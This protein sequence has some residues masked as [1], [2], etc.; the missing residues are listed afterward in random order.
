MCYY[1]LVNNGHQMMNLANHTTEGRSIFLLYYLADLTKAN[2]LEGTLLVNGLTDLTLNLLNLNC[3][4]SY[5]SLSV[6]YFIHTDSTSTCYGIG[7]A[8]LAQSL[9]GSLYQVVGVRRT[10]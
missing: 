6:E 8:H 7:I 10:L 4:H 9:D 2:S 3:C 5:T 1:C